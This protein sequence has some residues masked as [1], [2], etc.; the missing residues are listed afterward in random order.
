MEL[1]KALFDSPLRG[2]LNLRAVKELANIHYWGVSVVPVLLG[3]AIA[4]AYGGHFDFLV[5]LLLMPAAIAMHCVVNA[6]N[7]LFDFLRGTDGEE[8]K[9]NPRYPILYYGVRPIWVLLLGIFYLG[10]ALLLSL[11]VLFEVGPVLLVF[12]VVGAFVAVF[13]SGGPFPL[14]HYPLGELAS[15]FTMGGLITFAVYYGMIGSL[16]WIVLLFALPMIFTIGLV[17]FVNN[18]CDIEKDRINRK[19]IPIL[20]GRER[21]SVAFRVVYALTWLGAFAISLVYFTAGCWVVP[22]AAFLCR[23][24]LSRIWSLTYTPE[25]RNEVMP[26]FGSL[27]PWL[28]VSYLLGIVFSALV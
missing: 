19:T 8:N 28:N 25:T 24:K 23:K 13:Y 6:Y 26:L 18:I 27:I 9:N 20:L 16:D 17:C 22:L 11:Y 5:F 7:H 14:S 2:R 4:F 10:L 3:S 15:G 12:G 1:L 21:T